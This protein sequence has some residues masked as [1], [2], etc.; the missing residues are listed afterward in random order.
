MC[1]HSAWDAV[2]EHSC[3]ASVQPKHQG[4]EKRRIKQHKSLWEFSRRGPV[5][6]N[7]REGLRNF[8]E[9]GTED[10]LRENTEVW[11]KNQ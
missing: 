8:S 3:L 11:T 1:S 10:C 5:K 7:T 2:N 6:L 9:E 4:G